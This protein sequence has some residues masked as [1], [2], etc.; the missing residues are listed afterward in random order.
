MFLLDRDFSKLS[1]FSVSHWQP[2]AFRQI[3]SSVSASYKCA[4]QLPCQEQNRGKTNS[5]F[6][7]RNFHKAGHY[8]HKNAR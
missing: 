6:G 4:L 3:H 5:N 1:I 7:I 2:S 8:I